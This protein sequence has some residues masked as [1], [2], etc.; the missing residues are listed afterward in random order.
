MLGRASKRLQRSATSGSWVSSSKRLS[1]GSL[2][3]PA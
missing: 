1:G 3:R 2:N